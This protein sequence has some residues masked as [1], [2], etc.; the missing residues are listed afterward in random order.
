MQAFGRLTAAFLLVAMFAGCG[1]RSE[2][3]P[4]PAGETQ[5]PE[6]PAPAVQLD[7]VE[8]GD[9]RQ[10]QQRQ[11]LR[12]LAPR[13]EGQG[14]PRR[15]LPASEM[16][17]SAAA[18]AAKLG[19]TPHW[20]LVD[21]FNS[22][23]GQ[24]SAGA[25][26]VIVTN[27]TQT[28]PRE[29]M[30]DFTLPVNSIEEWVLMSADTAML[31][32]I[33]DLSGLTVAL[34]EGSSY[35]LS[36]S[37]T[38]AVTIF[39]DRT[40]G[41]DEHVDLVVS[42]DVDA[43]IMDSNQAAGLL[44]YR[45]DFRR[46]LTLPAAKNIAWAVRKGNPELL[47]ALNLY[48]SEIKLGASDEAHVGD[49][50]AIHARGTLRVIMRNG[51]A[52]YFLWKGELRGFEYELAKWFAGSLSLRL[53]VV[54]P[55]ADAD[56]F[57]MLEAGEGDLIA[58]AITI[59]PRRLERPIAFSKPYNTVSEVFVTSDAAPPVDSLVALAGR[60]VVAHPNSSYWESLAAVESRHGFRLLRAPAD[61][62]TQDILRG[63]EEGDFDVSLV[64]SHIV[65]IETTFSDE[66]VRGVALGKDVQHGW[67][68][69]SG[70]PMLT[71]A[72][73]S[74]FARHY[75]GLEFNVRYNRYFR[76][77]RR[78]ESH[79]QQRLAAADGLSPFDEMV[80][81]N[82]R[83]YTFDW[84]L[85]VSQMFQESRFDPRANSFAGARGLL[86]VLPRTARELGIKQPDQLYDPATGI[87]AGIQ[88]LNWARDRFPDTLPVSERLWFS[89]AA[90]NAGFG[91]VYDARRL[92]RR[93]G[94]NPDIWFD[95][96][97]KTMLLLAKREYA[98]KARYGYVRGQEPVAY[99]Q[100]IRQRYRG[101]VTME[102]ATSR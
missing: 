63:I 47:S 36:A 11:V 37:Q 33:D 12:F 100:S 40:Y 93:Q 61:F 89:L 69:R 10:I 51:P 1:D 15:G 80:R 27:F 75:K 67:V 20:V 85:I 42:G 4:V 88:Y 24:L 5:T 25:G 3:R 78:M 18:F 50:P 2:E 21:E 6:A 86:Q 70:N 84:R 77:K 48:I 38:D 95:N 7:Y 76:D 23:M 31:E 55:P 91:H 79:H 59:T 46:V 14:L 97:E 102:A 81:D 41:P 87:A 74:F 73:N 39:T 72:V 16:R 57:D 82:A 53:E 64:D 34:P 54:V 99:V 22:L 98:R 96:V 60:E 101:Y 9:L 65:D 13:W 52:T 8:T 66:L 44:R 83:K 92:A 43:T 35:A 62:D 28:E 32:T 94:L 71:E 19:L 68:T 90:Y 45:D 56:P 30:V 26:D 29:A 49:L 17:K 58:S